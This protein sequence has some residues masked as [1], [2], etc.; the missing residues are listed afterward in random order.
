MS[1]FCKCGCGKELPSYYKIQYILGHKIISKKSI[2]CECKC[3]GLTSP[4]NRFI[5]GHTN[6]GIKFSKEHCEK[7]SISNTGN[8]HTKETNKKISTIQKELHKNPDSVYNSKKYQDQLKRQIRNRDKYICKLCG[9]HANCVHHI[10]YDKQI[11]DEENLITLCRSC[12]VKTNANREDWTRHFKEIK[13]ITVYICTKNRYDTTLPMVL[14]SIISQTLKPKKLIII[15]DSDNPIDLRT[16]SHYNYLFQ[17]MD[18]KKIEWSVIFGA[19]KGQ[20]YSHQTMNNSDSALLLRV[21]DD[22]ILEPDVLEKL[23]YVMRKDVG[24]VGGSILTPPVNNNDKDKASGKIEDI[25]STPN[26]QW[27]EIDQT[28][29][30]DHLHCSFL[31][32]AGIVDYDLNL[33]KVAF[34]EETIFTYSLKKAGYSIW[35]TPAITWHLRNPQGGIRDGIK[36]LYEHDEK[37]FQ[38]FLNQGYN[39]K[40]LI[41]LDNGIGDHI[42]FSAILPDIKKKYGEVTIACC[43]PELFEGENCISIA[44]AKNIVGNNIDNYQIYKYMWDKNWKDSL[45]NAFRGMYL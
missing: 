40:K 25:Y 11:C 2:L 4:G 3:G 31:Y 26:K 24:A 15:D 18:Y 37:I 28:E 44:T 16:L 8:I 14:Q 23:T 27:Y 35:I 36:E 17:I 29:S 34:R 1:V 43:Y 7:I 32:R 19:K 41:I 9:A 12:H 33:S 6:K 38:E 39:T 30:I 10:N 45:E 22:T 20:N 21:D 13:N 42:V 5:R